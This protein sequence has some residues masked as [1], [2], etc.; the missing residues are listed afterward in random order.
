MVEAMEDGDDGTVIRLLGE[1]VEAFKTELG[2]QG[3]CSSRTDT[4]YFLYLNIV[5]VIIY[6]M[7]IVPC[8]CMLHL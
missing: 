6:T 4:L 5:V 1:A 8:T 7:Y 2:K 3:T